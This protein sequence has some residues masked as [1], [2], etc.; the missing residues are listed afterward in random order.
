M[1]NFAY[2]LTLLLVCSFAFTSCDKDEPMIPN[3]EEVITTVIYNLT[4]TSGDVVV[5]S[6][7]DLDGDTGGDDPVIV[8]GTLGANETYTGSI[9]LLNESVTPTEDIG[10]EVAEEDDEHQLFF[11]TNLPGITVTYDDADGDGNPVGLK[12]MLTTGDVGSGTITI[13]LKHEPVKDASGVAEGDIT[14]AEG[15]TD[16]EVTIPINVV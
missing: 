13:T 4:S 11:E 16:A 10:E 14:N 8:G 1:K 3:P 6:W 2:L 5:L 9:E 15:S 7:Q 12:T